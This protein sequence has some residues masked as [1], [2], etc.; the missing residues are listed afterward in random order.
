MVTM[1]SATLASLREAFNQA[2]DQ[3]RVI[4]LLSPT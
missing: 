1:T 3:T 2:K 4:L